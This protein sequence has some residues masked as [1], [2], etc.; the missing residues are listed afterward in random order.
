MTD[1]FQIALVATIFAAASVLIGWNTWRGLRFREHPPTLLNTAIPALVGG[2]LSAGL[3][4]PAL[5]VEPAH[6][7]LALAWGTMT[8]ALLS[9]VVTDLVDHD[10]WLDVVFGGAAAVV[11]FSTADALLVGGRRSPLDA[12]VGL[13]V[14]GAASY[15][16]QRGAGLWARLRGLEFSEGDEDTDYGFGDTAAWLLIGS[17]LGWQ[18]GFMAFFGSAILHGLLALPILLWSLAKGRGFFSTHIPMLPSIAVA[19]LVTLAY[20]AGLIDLSILGL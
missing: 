8:A 20:Y 2:A 3:A 15:L 9:N 4:A 16:L 14:L 7:L 1:L 19:T 11:L 13:V 10:V 12:L 17:G 18:L 5:L 6:P